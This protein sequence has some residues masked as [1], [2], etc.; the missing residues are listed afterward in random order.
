VLLGTVDGRP[1]LVDQEGH[2]LYAFARDTAADSACLNQCALTWPPFVGYA[3]AGDGLRQ[4]DFATIAR[5]DGHSQ[6][7]Y[8]GR[9]LYYFVG[10]G[11][12]GDANGEG[13]AGAWYPIGADG[14][15]AR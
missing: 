13:I 10:D 6:V 5:A 14:R 9:P 2:T 15:P 12:P 4:R 7:T 11:K 8:A 3:R 1:A